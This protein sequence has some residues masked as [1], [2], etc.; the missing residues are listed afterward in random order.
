[1]PR[2]LDRQGSY[3]TLL[4]AVLLALIVA[5]PVAHAQDSGSETVLSK[6]SFH[7]YSLVYSSSNSSIFVYNGADT[8][9]PTYSSP[10]TVAVSCSVRQSAQ[11]WFSEIDAWLGGVSWI[12]QPL[13]E[14]MTIRGS[15]SMTVWMSTPDPAPAA[16][17]YVFGISEVDSMGT[18]VGEPI[19]QYYYGYGNV[20]SG[21]ATPFTL[22]FSADQTYTKG[23]IIGFFVI[24]GSTTQGWRY[25]VYFDSPSAN[26][27]AELPVLTVPVP[28]FSQ[29]GIAIVFTLTVFSSY[30]MARRRNSRRLRQ[31]IGKSIGSYAT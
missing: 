22:V 10:P 20:F 21:S 8:N 25:Q 31:T 6:M 26:S 17:G 29:I 5:V 30:V 14:D 9:P 13:A 1:M 28:E 24:V 7:M 15:V 16:S 11:V 2:S 23:N 27:S 18:P 4:L 19:Y 3:A 12:T